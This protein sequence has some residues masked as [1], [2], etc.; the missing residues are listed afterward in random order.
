MGESKMNSS[1]PIRVLLTL[2]Q[3]KILKVLERG[4]LFT[5]REIID[6]GDISKATFYNNIKKLVRSGVVRESSMGKTRVY[7]INR[8]GLSLL[9]IS[10]AFSRV[11]G[12]STS[13]FENMRKKLEEIISVAGKLDKLTSG[14]DTL[15]RKES[16][17]F[18][19]KLRL[20]S[21]KQERDRLLAGY[22][23]G[24]GHAKSEKAIFVGRKRKGVDESNTRIENG[25]TEAIFGSKIRPEVFEELLAGEISISEL[26]ISLGVSQSTLLAC[27]APLLPYR[28]V[29][30][31]HG[32]EKSVAL[33]HGIPTSDKAKE[34]VS[35][36][37]MDVV[38]TRETIRKLAHEI[39]K[40]EERD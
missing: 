15:N 29:D 39:A 34:L 30:V 28:V 26:A 5:G 20:R 23:T 3:V 17:S 11:N 9:Q 14:I 40:H 7:R 8:L 2:T 33:G 25:V 10:E 37:A 24:I 1:S 6:L 32:M 13:D 16:I 19:D 22:T 27:I 4:E 35:K 21:L 18:P 12:L 31:S 38:R 36:L